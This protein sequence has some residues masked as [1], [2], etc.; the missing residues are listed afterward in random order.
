[1]SVTEHEVHPGFHA[2]EDLP[3]NTEVMHVIAVDRHVAGSSR[4]D[5][6]A[7]DVFLKLNSTITR[8]SDL[9]LSGETNVPEA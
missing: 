6:V 7:A 9:M 2:K 4:R 5:M 3:E 1:V 8:P